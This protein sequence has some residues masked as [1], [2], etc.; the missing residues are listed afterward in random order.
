MALIQAIRN[1]D[2]PE[3]ERIGRAH[4]ATAAEIRL[5]LIASEIE[6]RHDDQG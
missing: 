6:T 4:M 5:K 3:A 2:A 1:Q